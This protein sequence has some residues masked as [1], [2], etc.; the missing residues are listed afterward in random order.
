M[1]KKKGHNWIPANAGMVGRSVIEVLVVFD[2][3][4]IGS[5]LYAILKIMLN[6]IRSIRIIGA[7]GRN[8]SGKDEVLKY[9][10]AKYAV[11]FLATGDAV[12]EIA[13]KDGV[14]PTRENLGKISEKYFRELGKGCFVKMLAYKLKDSG[15]KAAG[16]SGI[17]SLDDVKILKDI[18]GKDFVLI[19]VNVSD[20]QVRFKRMT[21][22][23][24]TRDPHSYEQFLSQEENEEKLFNIRE[25][26]KLADYTVNNDSS[27]ADMH[28]QIDRLVEEGKL[29][30]V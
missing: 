28:Q 20:P 14:E 6:S 19:D 22:R 3:G 10:E 1:K 25:A 18:F 13:K 29:L 9:L 24:E 17:R 23:N 27:L 26:E 12:R 8:G 5:I 21:V 11:P 15:L 2:I 16:I 4:S 7:V 30:P